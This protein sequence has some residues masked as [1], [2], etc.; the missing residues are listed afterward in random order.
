VLE[1][2]KT[3]WKELLTFASAIEQFMPSVAVGSELTKTVHDPLVR[4]HLRDMTRS[5]LKP[6]FIS[7]A[8]AGAIYDSLVKVQIVNEEAKA[9]IEDYGSNASLADKLG[10]PRPLQAAKNVQLE[11]ISIWREIRRYATEDLELKQPERWW[12]VLQ[13]R[14]VKALRSQAAEISDTPQGKV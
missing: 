11:L 7:E 10:K 6:T 4:E 8:K 14:P 13:R 5:V 9:H 3:E 1:N 2:K 12:K